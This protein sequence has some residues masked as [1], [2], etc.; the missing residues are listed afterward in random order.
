VV[1][2]PPYVAESEYRHLDPSVRDWEPR[3]ALVAGPGA[4]GAEG[5]AAIEAII[6]GA[7]RWLHRA[8]AVVIEIAPYQAQ[9]SVDAA[10]RAGFGQVTTERDLAGRRRMLVARC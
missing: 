2:N 7:P 3:G 5:M 8:G 10:R 4:G 9:A 1:S 6:A